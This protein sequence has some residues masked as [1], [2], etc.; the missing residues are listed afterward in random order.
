MQATMIKWYIRPAT[1]V[2]AG[3]MAVTDANLDLPVATE[4]SGAS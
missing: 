2:D 3:Y 4:D 1:G